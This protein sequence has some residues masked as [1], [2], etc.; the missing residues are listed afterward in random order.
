MNS[1]LLAALLGVALVLPASAAGAGEVK[2]VLA[3]GRV[4]V[5]AENATVREILAEWARVG[6]TT[7]VNAD[8]LTGPPITIQL[9]NVPEE[10]ALDSLLRSAGGYILAPRPVPVA[11]QSQVA[12]ILIYPIAAPP[13]SAAATPT[14]VARPA[15][16]MGQGPMAGRGRG[17][18]PVS[19]D[20]EDAMME[21]ARAM[22]VAGGPGGPGMMRGGPGNIVTGRP[23]E[24][25]FN[26]ANP[27][28]LRQSAEQAAGQD[29]NVVSGA[30]GNVVTPGTATGTNPGTAIGPMT[31]NPYTGQPMATP[32]GSTPA[33]TPG[34]VPGS[35]TRPGVTV[36]VIKQQGSVQ[37]PYG[38]PA[39]VIPGSAAGT[40]LEPD[41]AK[42]I[43]PPRVG[44]D[45]PT[46]VTIK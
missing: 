12:S 26:Y 32:Q 41:R 9:Q 40:T 2:I 11:G 30:S 33:T 4:T 29:P 34:A 37:G 43:N 7:L 28:Q 13:V 23:E 42:Y 8:R 27:M 31:V 16:V 3:A 5:M 24:T 45:T 14:P 38:L 17:A 46:P 35:A 36:P 22:G 1:R 25:M 21:A 10:Q 39:E 44:G 18:Q 6:Q 15:D 20:E 19:Q